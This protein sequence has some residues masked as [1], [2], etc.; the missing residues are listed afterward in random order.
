LP[1]NSS[2]YL[3]RSPGSEFVLLLPSSSCLL[4]AA[5]DA[6]ESRPIAPFNRD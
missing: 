1:S 2:P 5:I 3:P 4:P 6:T